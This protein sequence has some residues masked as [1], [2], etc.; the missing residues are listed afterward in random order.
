MLR[1]LTVRT[2]ALGFSLM[3]AFSA[4][5]STPERLSDSEVTRYF[6]CSYL[7][8]EDSY[9]IGSYLNKNYEVQW[10]SYSET[11]KALV[12]NK[13]AEIS[14]E[15]GI[16]KFKAEDSL[17]TKYQCNRAYIDLIGLNKIKI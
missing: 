8:T 7:H 9:K 15:Q 10:Y 3:L 5:S 1:L 17:S 16:S 12:N 2:F 14:R 11:Y 13:L 4:H 6:I